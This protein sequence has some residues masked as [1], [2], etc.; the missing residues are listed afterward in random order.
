MDDAKRLFCNIS[1]NYEGLNEPLENYKG[2]LKIGKPSFNQT[3]QNSGVQ[4]RSKGDKNFL[5]CEGPSGRRIVRR[6]TLSGSVFKRDV[7]SNKF[8]HNEA[9]KQRPI[10]KTD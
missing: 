7:E 4:W 3:V 6:N 5:K 9:Q 10:S 8:V 1:S 2:I